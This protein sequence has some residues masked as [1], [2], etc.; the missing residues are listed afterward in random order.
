MPS[1]VSAAFAKHTNAKS[2]ATKT[3]QEGPPHPRMVDEPASCGVRHRDPVSDTQQ[4]IPDNVASFVTHVDTP[5]IFLDISPSSQ[6]LF[7]WSCLPAAKRRKKRGVSPS[8]NM[9]GV[10]LALLAPHRAKMRPTK[11]AAPARLLAFVPR[12]SS[13]LSVRPASSAPSTSS[14]TVTCS[15]K[16]I[17]TRFIRAAFL[18]KETM[19]VVPAAPA[20]RPGGERC[21]CVWHHL[22]RMFSV[23]WFRQQVSPRLAL[24]S[25]AL[26]PSLSAFF[27][28]CC[29]SGCA[30]RF[31]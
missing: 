4:S 2:V 27:L 16:S 17:A 15:T 11:I 21:V 3:K 25:P 10:H 20:E 24:S 23:C 14:T 1:L 8:K 28:R 22:K 6:L 9:C 31:F 26:F 5:A 19:V 12:D 30:C 13:K 29:S 7:V 18:R